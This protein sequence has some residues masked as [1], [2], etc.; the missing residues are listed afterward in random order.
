M[1]FYKFVTKKYITTLK[2]PFAHLV[3]GFLCPII[4]ILV[5]TSIARFRLT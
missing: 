1:Y 2:T 5:I 4:I 3:G